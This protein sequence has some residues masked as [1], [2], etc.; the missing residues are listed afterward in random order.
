M[1]LKPGVIQ[2]VSPAASPPAGRNDNNDDEEDSAG[3]DAQ[4]GVRANKFTAQDSGSEYGD[5][6]DVEMEVGVDCARVHTYK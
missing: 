3:A 5:I 1:Q 6:N 4:V 2:Q